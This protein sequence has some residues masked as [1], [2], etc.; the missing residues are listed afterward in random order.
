MC[1][2]CYPFFLFHSLFS[3]LESDTLVEVQIWKER[4]WIVV[5][6][7]LHHAAHLI[8]QKELCKYW[9]S[10]CWSGWLLWVDCRSP[11]FHLLFSFS[12]L[13]LL[14]VSVYSFLVF[15]LR[16]T[17]LG[18]SDPPEYLSG[19]VMLVSIR[20]DHKRCRG[21]WWFSPFLSPLKDPTDSSRSLDSSQS[22]SHSQ[23]ESEEYK[24]SK[25]RRKVKHVVFVYD[26]QWWTGKEFRVGTSCWVKS[27]LL[28][29]LCIWYDA[30]MQHNYHKT[31]FSKKRSRNQNKKV[32]RTFR[33]KWATEKWKSEYLKV[34]L[35]I[36]LSAVYTKDWVRLSGLTI[37]N[38]INIINST[39]RIMI[40]KCETFFFLPWFLIT[41]V[42]VAHHARQH[43]FFFS[44]RTCWCSVV[45]TASRMMKSSWCHLSLESQNVMRRSVDDVF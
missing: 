18:P 2:A 15:S 22:E 5:L 33:S 34:F 9:Q 45:M 8:L 25:E 24:K 19:L 37:T 38:S 11:S 31:L 1:S 39:I 28:L 26:V 7:N 12:S 4:I 20:H 17:S 13:S 42:S 36:L 44:F 32:W 14:F 23:S 6:R 35:Y 27:P 41:I 43:L 21:W 3:W 30:G 10:E 40:V 16:E 29:L